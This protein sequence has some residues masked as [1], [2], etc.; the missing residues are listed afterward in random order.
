MVSPLFL[1]S[2]YQEAEVGGEN[3]ECVMWSSGTDDI[4]SETEE[5]IHFPPFTIEKR[6][7][8]A[9]NDSRTKN[10]SSAWEFFIGIMYFCKTKV[11]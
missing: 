11:T 1:S 4:E 8:H 6:M 10:T 9:D 7:I 5:K 2:V 3:D